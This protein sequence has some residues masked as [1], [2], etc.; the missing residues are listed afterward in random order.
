MTIPA[1]PSRDKKTLPPDMEEEL[2]M[3]AWH[4]LRTEEEGGFLSPSA[5]PSIIKL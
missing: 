4:L 3:E 5:F 1:W 2:M